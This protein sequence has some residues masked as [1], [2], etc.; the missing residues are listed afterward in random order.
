MGKSTFPHFLF[1]EAITIRNILTR[2]WFVPLN[3][4]NGQIEM[5]SFTTAPYDYH[6]P[7]NYID[8]GSGCLE[9]G[10][11]S[12]LSK[13]SPDETSPICRFYIYNI[14]TTIFPINSDNNVP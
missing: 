5:L 2:K 14:V 6:G 1:D 7:T 9:R 4:L 3:G 8:V 11:Y 12:G 13:E 10:I